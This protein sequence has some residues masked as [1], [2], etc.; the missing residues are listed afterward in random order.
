MMTHMHKQNN[1]IQNV[2]DAIAKK[3]ATQILHQYGTQYVDHGAVLDK[4]VHIDSRSVELMI[5]V[6]L[7]RMF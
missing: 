1:S 3:P 2:V 4:Q 5:H 7:S 6:P